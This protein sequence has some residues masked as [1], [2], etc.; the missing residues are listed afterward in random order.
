MTAVLGAPVLVPRDDA[1]DKFVTTLKKAGHGVIH[2]ALTRTVGLPG[3]DRLDDPE[4]WETD[5]VVVTSRTTVGLL[6]DPLP[7]PVRDG[8]VKVA[9]V[10][11]ATARTLA[12]RGAEPDFVPSQH[13]GAGLVAEWPGG[14]CR[15]LLP[16]SELAAPTV[17][18]G[19]RK[20]GCTV[21]RIGIYTTE[22]LEELPPVLAQAWPSVGAVVVTASSVARALVTL[23]EPLG[24][25]H[26][27]LVA[28]GR[29]TAGTLAE[30]GH[31]A[32]AVAAA[33]T[34]EAVLA[35][36]NSLAV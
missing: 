2:T 12:E 23:V 30:L 34:P 5:W 22:P 33:P 11:R 14:A 29:P 18:D 8:R 10:G 1:H 19:L 28:L 4:V 24:W 35:A 7:Q 21:E 13:D 15:V 27:R 31:P 32:D 36:I 16:V 20:V 3:A 26:Q 25:R 6:P 17:P 9:A